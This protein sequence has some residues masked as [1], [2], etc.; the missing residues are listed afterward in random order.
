ME[1]I[2]EEEELYKLP[3]E[4]R[5][6][7]FRTPMPLFTM[8]ETY[9]SSV[10]ESDP[11]LGAATSGLSSEGSRIL[12]TVRRTERENVELQACLRLSSSALSNA[13][14]RTSI[15]SYHSAVSLSPSH[16]SS[17][18]LSSNRSSV[19]TFQTAMTS[20]SS[21]ENSRRKLRSAIL[22]CDLRVGRLLTLEQA[23]K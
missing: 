2:E 21:T 4:G 7:S 23:K 18:T 6:G 22:Q 20:G 13:T 17:W 15:S 1:R 5:G 14:K 8:P 9:C 10:S 11:P 19:A 3:K 16:W 12:D